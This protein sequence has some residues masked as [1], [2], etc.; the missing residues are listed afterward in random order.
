[1]LCCTVWL[2]PALGLHVAAAAYIG[3]L[4]LTGTTDCCR[5]CLW[6]GAA[7]MLALMAGK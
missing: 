6:G 4:K 5:L 3:D 7:D 1:M 2:L